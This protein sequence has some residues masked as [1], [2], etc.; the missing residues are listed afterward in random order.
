MIYVV[1]TVEE[2]Q[3]KVA[4]AGTV[5]VDTS[6]GCSVTTCVERIE[7]SVSTSTWAIKEIVVRYS[8]IA[9]F[10]SAEDCC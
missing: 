8:V 5:V 7:P 1:E 3:L 4:E 10:V 2:D 6:E 9:A